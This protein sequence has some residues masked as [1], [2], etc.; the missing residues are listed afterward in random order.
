M[1]DNA[2]LAVHVETIVRMYYY[3]MPDSVRAL[4]TQTFGNKGSQTVIFTS[5]T[6]DIHT[7]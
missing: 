6:Q 3:S 5:D 7:N 2:M 4:T 1:A